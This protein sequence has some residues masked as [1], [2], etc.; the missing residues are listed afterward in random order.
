MANWEPTTQTGR[1]KGTPRNW[2]TTVSAQTGTIRVATPGNIQT[3]I[4]ACVPGDVVYLSN[5]SYGGF[6]VGV[7]GTQANKIVIVAQNP[8]TFNARNVTVSGGRIVISGSHIIIGGFRYSWGTA[9]SNMIQISGG[10]IE[11]TDC[12]IRDVTS[13]SSSSRCIVV[14]ENGSNAYIH[15]NW[16]YNFAGPYAIVF[17]VT[18]PSSYAANAIIEYN[19]FDTLR[20][21]G[22][23]SS[24]NG[25]IFLQVGQNVEDY[26]VPTA[27]TFRYNYVYYCDNAELKTSY[28]NIFR[29]YFRDNT[30]SAM[31]FRLGEYN[32]FE[33]NYVQNCGR[34][35]RIFGRYGSVVNN[36]FVGNNGKGAVLVCEGSTYDQVINGTI[37][38]AQHVRAEY[39]LIA[40]NVIVAGTN[41]GIHIGDTQTGRNGASNP[42]PYSPIYT[43]I[44]NNIIT[45]AQGVA[46]YWQ[47]PDSVGATADNY[48]TNVTG[49]H[50]Y[51]GNEV[52]NNCIYVTGTAV[53]GDNSG[54][55]GS[56]TGYISW[57]HGTLTSGSVISGNIETNPQLVSTYRVNVSS[58][59]I[60]AGI[61]YNVNNQN[62]STMYDWDRDARLFGAA[63]DMGLDEFGSQVMLTSVGYLYLNGRAVQ[64]NGN[65]VLNRDVEAGTAILHFNGGSMP[66]DAYP[67]GGAL[68]LYGGNPG[69]NKTVAQG[70]FYLNGGVLSGRFAWLPRPAVSNTWSRIA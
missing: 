63:P 49:Y 4:N 1:D 31:G 45:A 12:D 41:R 47:T 57:T 7:S 43:Y 37:S 2:S 25:G 13:T 5:G 11:L 17:D 9:G 15:H 48:P 58:P 61:A 36:Y 29:N 51:V 6:T 44:Y 16:F 32:I 28:N 46:I 67:T 3:Q 53:V 35:I 30:T 22:G 21:V 64:A 14:N 60:N 50:Q 26:N 20:G 24:T 27:V 40:N 65:T 55:G 33:G 70:V 54:D 19:T 38:N 8:G 69:T 68:Y 18:P 42:Q 52:K 62:T 34:G 23:G 10:S 39:T 59:C 66:V 56:P